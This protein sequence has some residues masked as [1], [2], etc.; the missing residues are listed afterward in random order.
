MN[1]ISQFLILA[2]LLFSSCVNS[3]GLISGEDIKK[4]LS[5]N[6]YDVSNLE[7]G[8][9]FSVFN[10]EDGYILINIPSK[11][12][13]IKYKRWVN[14]DQICVEHKVKTRCRDVKKI[15]DGKYLL[16]TKGKPMREL[17]NYK[18]GSNSS[19]KKNK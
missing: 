5:G 19:F 14:D 18:K 2:S 1:H 8:K 10:R 16:L 11:N 4:L 12:K 3:S 6:M 15:G 9:K 7:N 13:T 17:S